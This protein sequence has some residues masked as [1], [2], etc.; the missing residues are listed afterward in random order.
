MIWLFDG[1]FCVLMFVCVCGD[2]WSIGLSV[3]YD[4]GWVVVWIGGWSSWDVWSF[5]VV[6]VNVWFLDSSISYGVIR[7]FWVICSRFV[8]EV[9]VV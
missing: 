2:W 6:W 8:F 5:L 9:C 1:S 4:R 7:D 3:G